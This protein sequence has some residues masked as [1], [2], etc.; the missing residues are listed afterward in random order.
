MAIVDVIQN[1]HVFRRLNPEQLNKI[2]DI[3][4]EETYRP[5]Q[6]VFKTGNQTRSFYIIEEG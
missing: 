2:A 1:S 5:G 6:Y 3:A 4:H